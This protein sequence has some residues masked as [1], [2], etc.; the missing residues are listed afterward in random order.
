MVFNFNLAQMITLVGGFAMTMFVVMRAPMTTWS[1]PKLPRVVLGL[2]QFCGRYT[3]EIF[4]GHLLLFKII[5]FCLYR[6]DNGL[7]LLQWQWF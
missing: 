5:Q 7:K 6:G 3:L 2:A 1:K 4:V